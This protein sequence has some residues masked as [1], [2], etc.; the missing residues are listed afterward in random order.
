M[1]KIRFFIMAFMLV[2]IMFL[3]SGCGCG[4]Y[5][6]DYFGFGFNKDEYMADK[7]VDLLLKFDETDEWYTP[8]NCNIEGDIKI[9]E[10][11]EIV[12]Y[13][14]DGYRS[15][16]MHIKE[17]YLSISIQYFEGIHDCSKEYNGTPYEIR[18]YVNMPSHYEGHYIGCN[19]KMLLEFCNK[20][21]K[22]R[23]AVFDKDGNI[24]QIS[25]KIPLVSLGNFYL[26]NISYNVEKNRIKPSYIMSDDLWYFTS[27]IWLLLQVGLIGC[28]ITLKVYKI[29]HNQWDRTYKGYIIAS[30]IF[31]IPNAI[32]IIIDLYYVLG[33]ST[34]IYDFFINMLIP[35][36]EINIFLIGMPITIAVLLHFINL[37]KSLQK[38]I[39]NLE[40]E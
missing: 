34:T 32:L 20:Y 7:Y 25:K 4:V 40:K 5:Y 36:F 10:N 22:C 8:Y 19:D 14:K 2:G 9:P 21:K 11:S 1:R 28:I 6:N 16:L 3:F 39:K 31:N 18:Q 35:L 17:A 23:V 37:E 24:V 12:K 27:K 30:S 29:N 13:N 15:M 26:Q 38:R 33:M